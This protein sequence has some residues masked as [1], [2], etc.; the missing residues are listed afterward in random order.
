MSRRRTARMLLMIAVAAFAWCLQPGYAGE[1]TAA[2][3]AAAGP[4][5]HLK[6][7]RQLTF[8]RQNAEAYFSFDGT[9]LI[10]QSTNNWMGTS[11]AASKSSGVS[12]LGCYQ[13]STMDLENGAIRL[14]S[15]G[16]GVTTC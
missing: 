1:P 13:M 2:P 9:K 6:N 3:Q 8:G 14:V 7:V 12:D 5:R 16:T 11:Y 4:E 15:T 10:F